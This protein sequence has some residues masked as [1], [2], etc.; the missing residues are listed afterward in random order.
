M[1]KRPAA[2]CER[3]LLPET[4]GPRDEVVKLLP[5]PTADDEQLAEGL[6]MADEAV[7][8]TV[9]AAGLAA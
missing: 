4:A 7:G 9:G 3:G 6:E 8:A 2:A 5:P 1:R